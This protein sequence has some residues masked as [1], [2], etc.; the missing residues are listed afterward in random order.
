LVV[1][2]VGYWLIGLPL[3]TYLGLHT[4]AGPA[5][6]WWGLVVGLAVVAVILVLRVRLRLRGSLARVR[7]D[8]VPSGA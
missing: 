6:M 8:T 3:A 1:N 4:A 7:V 5:G 2:V